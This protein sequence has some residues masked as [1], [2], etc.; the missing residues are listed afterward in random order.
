[1]GITN[2][3]EPTEEYKKMVPD[4]ICLGNEIRVRITKSGHVAIFTDNGIRILQQV[5]FGKKVVLPLIK[6]L[7]STFNIDK[8]KL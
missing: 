5:Y 3:P 8:S 4:S 6:I 2:L 7:I 1:M